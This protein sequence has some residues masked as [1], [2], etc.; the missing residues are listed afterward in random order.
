MNSRPFNFAV[1]PSD[2]ALMLGPKPDDVYTVYGEYRKAPTALADDDA[3]PTIKDHLHMIVVYKAM[4]F[5]GLEQ[6]AGEVITRGERG[7]QNLLNQ[8]EREELPSVG[9]GQPFA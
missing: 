9:F 5:Y 2:D 1:R 6:G 4:I 7:Y 3:E 8:L